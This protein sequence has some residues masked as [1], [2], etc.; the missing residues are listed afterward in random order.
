MIEE[1]YIAVGLATLVYFLLK[2]KRVPVTVELTPLEPT[3]PS[4][5]MSICSDMDLLNTDPLNTI[6][7]NYMEID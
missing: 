2:G 7:E 1:I 6:Q 3:P 4:S 5:P